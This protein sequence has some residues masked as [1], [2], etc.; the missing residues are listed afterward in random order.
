MVR[1]A[2]PSSSTDWYCRD[3]MSSDWPLLPGDHMSLQSLSPGSSSSHRP[4]LLK[5][6]TSRGS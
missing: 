1:A 5:A 2:M 4:T 3:G 6:L